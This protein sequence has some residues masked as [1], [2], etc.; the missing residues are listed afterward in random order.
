MKSAAPIA[1]LALACVLTSGPAAAQDRTEADARNFPNR[2]VRI[3]VP[4]PAGGPS[5]IVARVIGQKMSEDWGQ[6]VVIENRPG[7]NTIIGAQAAAKSAPDGYTLFMAIDSTLV[8][9]QYLY[10]SLPYDPLDDFV[11]ITLTAKTVSVLAVLAKDGPKDVADLIAR[12]KAAPGKLNYGA[13]TITT[14]LMG[15]LFHKAAGI[16][17]VYVPFK[18]TPATVNGLMTGSVQLIY[19]ANQNVAPLIA[20]GR[21]R[22]LGKLDRDAPPSMAGIPPLADAAGLRDLEDISVWLGLVAPKGTPKPIVDKINVEVVKIL[23]D[24]GV[25]EKSERTGNY[26]VTNSPEQFAVFIRKEADRWSRVIKETGI[27]LD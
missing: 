8:M 26:P 2:A 7:A 11:P 25:K 21:L 4:F 12:A 15:H 24:P 22:A 14:Q 6:P 17:I 5:D 13:G 18:G 27:K 3:I 1:A 10:K 23:S 9:N 19:G 16:D 20:D